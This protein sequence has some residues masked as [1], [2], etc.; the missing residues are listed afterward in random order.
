MEEGKQDYNPEFQDSIAGDDLDNSNYNHDTGTTNEWVPSHV[1]LSLRQPLFSGVEK[2]S[3]FQFKGLNRG[4]FFLQKWV[5]F[6]DSWGRNLPQKWANSSF[7]APFENSRFWQLWRLAFWWP[8]TVR[9]SLKSRESVPKSNFLG[10]VLFELFGRSGPLDAQ[11]SGNCRS[12]SLAIWNRSDSNHP[13]VLPLIP[14]WFWL[15]FAGVLWFQIVRFHWAS[16]WVPGIVRQHTLR[17]VL[18]KFWGGFWARVL[19]RVLLWVLQKGGS[20]RGS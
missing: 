5:F 13:D 11:I 19:R 8:E 4:P 9:K 14:R 20:R 6:K 12:N 3:W 18:R 2:L 10:V 15:P 17:R 16:N 7:E 1:A